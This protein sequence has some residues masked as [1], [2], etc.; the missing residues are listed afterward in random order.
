MMTSLLLL[1]AVAGLAAFFLRHA[2]V[3]RGLWVTAAAGHAGLTALCWIQRP[4]PGLDGW[5]AVDAAGLL[6]LSLTSVLFLAAAVYGVGYLNQ[7]HAAPAPRE[8]GEPELLSPAPESVFIGCQLLF[9]AA[10]TLVALS[11]HF[12]LLWV[13]IEATTL[14]SAPLIYYHRNR[15]SLE[16]TWKYLLICSVGIALALLGTFFLGVA[17][18]STASGKPLALV[19]ENLVQHGAELQPQWLKAAF[20]L[21]L[22]GYGAK[23]GLAPLHTWLPDAHSEAP[24]V[25]SALLSGALLNCAF[26]GLWRLQEVCQ[27]AGLAEFGQH[28]LLLLGLSSLGVAAVF[29]LGQKDYKRLLAYSS[30]EHMGLLALGVGV[31]GVGA[32]A[33]LL[34]AI[35]HS[36][37]KAGLFLTAGLILDAYHSKDISR[38]RGVLRALP[39]PGGLWLAGFLAI[40]GAP[41]FGSFF[42]EWLLLRGAVE[43]GHLWVAV[44]ALA[45]LAVAFMGMASAFLEMGQGPSTCP[46]HGPEQAVERRTWMA[47]PPLVLICLAAVLGLYLPG[48]LAALVR[49]AARAA[50][51]F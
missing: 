46:A 6:F 7:Q 47:M 23:M 35:F 18:I 36:L 29:I 45:A 19:V 21:M 8:T 34:H 43:R 4:P 1:P 14:A 2:G 44:A 24:S 16:A 13:A 9:L 50:G 28:L 42:S 15:R 51:G 27:A 25:V 33:A 32:M 37:A 3:R 11:H 17:T 20:I 31:G 12:G 5:L 38:V 22:V 30:I 48:P 26:L 41:P 49:E 10:M 39:L 40:T